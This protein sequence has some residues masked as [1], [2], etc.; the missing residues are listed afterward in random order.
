MKLEALFAKEVSIRLVEEE[1]AFVCTVRYGGFLGSA[2]QFALQAA[3][4]A[5]PDRQEEGPP[6]VRTH[7]RFGARPQG[8]A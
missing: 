8:Q 5:L 2:T 4:A 6:V 1:A 3:P 7:S